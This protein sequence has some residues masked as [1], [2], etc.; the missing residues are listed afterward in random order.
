MLTITDDSPIA[1][2]NYHSKNRRQWFFIQSKHT[3]Q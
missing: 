3:A 2:V 1:L